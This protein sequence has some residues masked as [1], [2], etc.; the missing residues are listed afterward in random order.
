MAAASALQ[1]DANLAEA[2][3]SMAVIKWA[4]DWNWPAAEADFKRALE[5]NPG[6]ATVRHQYARFLMTMG[7]FDEAIAEAK[8]SVVLD[9]VSL[10]A[11][12]GLAWAYLWA[13]RYGDGIVQLRKVLH[14][15]PNN[16]FAQAFLA[17][18]FARKGMLAEALTAAERARESSAVGKDQIVDIW[19]AISYVLLGRRNEA[20]NLLEIW[21]SMAA[22]RYVDPVTISAFCMWL[23]DIDKAISYYHKGLEERSPHV[24]WLKTTPGAAAE[25]LSDPRGQDI[26][27]RIGFPP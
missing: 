11:E 20:Q 13:R 8:T 6:S 12:F 9:P 1:L 15:D 21:E 7:R 3:A 25:F 14:L 16:A 5:L 18:A 10:M 22:E 23:G 24:P 27:R 2:H 19:L 17:F 4:Y 26:L